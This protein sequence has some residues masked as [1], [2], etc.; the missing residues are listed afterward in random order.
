MN[1]II[2]V[3]PEELIRT[4]T[5]FD[6]TGN[7][8]RSIT[9]EMISLINGISGTVWSSEAANAY[10]NKFTGLQSDMDRMF[11]MISEHVTDLNAMAKEYQT[12]EETNIQVS[13][14]LA[15]DIIH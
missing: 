10:K 9:S 8:I 2:K 14:A 7:V 12:T 15:S 11:K 3:T 5:S 1:G 13:Q 6:N 4:A